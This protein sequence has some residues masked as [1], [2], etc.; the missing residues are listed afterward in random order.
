LLSVEPRR[1]RADPSAPQDLKSLTD[2][3][4]VRDGLLDAIHVALESTPDARARMIQLEVKPRRC[5]RA[6]LTSWTRSLH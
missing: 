5:S 3:R 2:L 6:W 1:K 4:E